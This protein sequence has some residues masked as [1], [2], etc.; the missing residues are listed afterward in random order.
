MQ[1]WPP[2]ATR[3]REY[4][5]GRLRVR[6]DQLEYLEHLLH[7]TWVTVAGTRTRVLAGGVHRDSELVKHMNAEL[8]LI[9]SIQKEIKRTQEDL[10]DRARLSPDAPWL[11]D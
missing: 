9:T 4:T 7:T 10:H 5:N 1:R 2:V 6:P 8:R 3:T 11:A